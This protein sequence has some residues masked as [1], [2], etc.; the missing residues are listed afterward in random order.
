MARMKQTGRG[1]SGGGSIRQKTLKRAGK[2][3]TYWEARYTAGYNPNTG[4]QIQRT[5]TGKTKSE[6]AQ[7]LRQKLVE[8]DMGT[9]QEPCQLMVGEWL[10]IWMAEYNVHL[11]PRTAESY[12]CQIEN[13]LRPELGKYKLEDLRP[14]I[15]QHFCNE[16]LRSG[17]T[18]KTVKT[19]HGVLHKALEQAV[20]LGYIRTNPSTGCILPR[21]TRKPLA[22][23]DDETIKRFLTAVQGHR[24]E[25]IYLVD[26]FTG[27]RKG[28]VMGLTWSSVDFRKGTLLIDKQLQRVPGR[29]GSDRYSLTSTKSGK[30][31]KITPAPY[32]MQ[33]LRR[34]K[35]RQAE[36]RLRAGP[37]WE[38]QDLVFT[39]E[40][41][42]YLIPETVYKDFKKVM[43]AIGS[44]ETRLHDLRHSYAVAAIKSGDDIK[45][46]QENLGHASA[47]FT[48]D[49]YGH[50]TDEM[51]SE[52]AQRME[53]FIEKLL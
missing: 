2:T 31:R 40:L 3:Y 17:L 23:L 43:A 20:T 8:L 35:S 47:V 14:H 9:Y 24:F 15:V 52:S 10:D 22:P 21:V 53:S 7:K 42:G 37:A 29:K 46:V 49:V 34:Q 51:R 45:T 32:V 5:I 28:E 18:P 33:L 25:I 16:L 38:D 13:H 48:L 4:R 1:A 41:G 39:N 30:A 26:L 36:W 11:K 19:I 50:V 44:P 27:L 6:V 12:R